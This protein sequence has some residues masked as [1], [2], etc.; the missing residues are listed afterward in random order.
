MIDDLEALEELVDPP[1][2][3]PEEP[4]L[5]PPVAAT[6]EIPRHAENSKFLSTFPLHG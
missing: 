1:S 2:S 6:S 4:S 3:P 5:V